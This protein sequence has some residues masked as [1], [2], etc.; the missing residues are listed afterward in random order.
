[1]HENN[2]FS[3]TV[4]QGI[5]KLYMPVKILRYFYRKRCLYNKYSVFQSGA[6]TGAFPC[7]NCMNEELSMKPNITIL[8]ADAR[9]MHGRTNSFSL[10][11]LLFAFSDCLSLALYE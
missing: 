5:Y 7:T 10:Y 6:S 2:L 8:D 4:E 3:P 11:T 9:P 1:M